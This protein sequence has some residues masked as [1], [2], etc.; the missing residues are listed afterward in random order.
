MKKIG[1]IDY[2]L[3]EY[4]AFHGFETVKAYNEKTGENFAITA[5]WAEKD[6]EGGVSTDEFCARY[7]VKKCATI[8]ELASE[9]DYFIILSPDNSE[10]KLEYAKEAFKYGKR[11]FMDKTFC[12]SYASAVAIFDEA[13][14]TGV[15]FFSSSSL[16]YATELNPYMGTAKSVFVLGSGV[17]RGDYAVHYLEIIVACMGVGAKQVCFE[18]RGNQEWANIDYVDGRKASFGISMKGSYIDFGVFVADKDGDSKFLP[19]T[20]DFFALQMADVLRF[21]NTGEVSFDEAQTLE[22]MKIRD[23]VLQSKSEGGVWVTL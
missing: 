5:V 12:D 3:D 1:Y 7:G 20:S 17:S 13:K 18:Q 10:K 2:Y 15:K 9:V 22:L 6:K 19:I 8:A 11:T 23:G 14:K 21:F 16:R 4:H